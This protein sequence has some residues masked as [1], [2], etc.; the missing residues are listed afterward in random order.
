MAIT[1]RMAKKRAKPKRLKLRVLKDGDVVYFDPRDSKAPSPGQS[2]GRAEFSFCPVWV[3]GKLKCVYIYHLQQRDIEFYYRW[4]LHGRDSLNI[5]SWT[6][7]GIEAPRT[8]LH[9]YCQEHKCAGFRVYV[10]DGAHSFMLSCGCVK[11]QPE[12]RS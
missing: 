4:D 3:R 10:P 2:Y 1:D 11:F 12:A 7:K 8:W 9:Y 5:D 6:H